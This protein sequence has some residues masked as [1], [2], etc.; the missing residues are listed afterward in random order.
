[1]LN[2]IELKDHLEYNKITYLFKLT[3]PPNHTVRRFKALFSVQ[4]ITFMGFVCSLKVLFLFEQIYL[5]KDYSFEH[6]NFKE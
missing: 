1:M 2:N 5:Q 6:I 3:I 4:T